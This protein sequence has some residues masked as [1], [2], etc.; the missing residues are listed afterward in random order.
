M[1]CDLCGADTVK[2][3]RGIFV[4]DHDMSFV[5]NDRFLNKTQL[6]CRECTVKFKLWFEQE[7]KK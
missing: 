3:L 2:P 5:I 6:L 7:R 1:K 4:N